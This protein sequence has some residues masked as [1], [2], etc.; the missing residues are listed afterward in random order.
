MDTIKAI[1]DEGAN[2]VNAPPVPGDW[3]I[4]TSGRDAARMQQEDLKK[5]D[6]CTDA[7]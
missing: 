7:T 6:G 5:D 3:P 2:F 4:Y 1:K